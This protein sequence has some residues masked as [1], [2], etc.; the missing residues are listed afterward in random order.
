MLA[1]TVDLLG[2]ALMFRGVE[3]SVVGLRERSDSLDDLITAVASMS[4]GPGP[5]R[6]AIDICIGFEPL[7]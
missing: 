2:I 4:P 3:Q 6:V 7:L 1:E 5:R